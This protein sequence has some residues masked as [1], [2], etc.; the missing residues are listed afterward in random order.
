MTP[1]SDDASSGRG[2][3]AYAGPAKRATI[4]DVAA[5][6]GVSR[7]TVT[8]AMNAMP[9]IRR[10]TRQ[11]VQDVARELGYTPSRFAKGLVQGA[12]TSVGLSIPDLTNPYY[13]AFASS[14]VELAT[15]RGW[16]VVMDDYGH[17]GAT[18]AESVEHLAPQVDAVIGYLGGATDEAQAVLGRRPLVVLDQ[19]AGS[20]S[21]RI[22]FDYGHAA[23][24]A[25]GHL[26]ARGCR[27]LAYIDRADSE[28]GRAT[29][30]PGHR[31]ERGHASGSAQEVVTARGQAFARSAAAAGVVLAVSVSPESAADARQ[32]TRRLLEEHPRTDGIVVFNDLMAAG[33]LK[34]LAES[35]RAVPADCAVIGMDG[36]PLG[37]LLT[38][39]LTTLALDLREVGRAAVE[40]L[41]G[42][43]TG[44]IEP[45][46]PGSELVL[47]H[48]LVL[49]QSA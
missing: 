24:A 8:R 4:L 28:A 23:Q 48:R 5:A 9:G 39:E 25:L 33:A 41:D 27:H 44:S 10:E 32:V 26:Q 40:L 1:P 13:P 42:L 12:R 14:V 38:P 19:P 37:E 21:G 3:G 35:G 18:G 34:A 30:A 20:A 22:S 17:G 46:G 47:R 6:A 16:H 2:T 31:G 11:R 49:R 15:Q 29:V 7:Q 43:L 45:G 36:I